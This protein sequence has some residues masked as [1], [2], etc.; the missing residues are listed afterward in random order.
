MAKRTISNVKLGVFVL[1]GLAFLVLLLYMIGKNQNLFGATYKLRARFDNVQGLMTGNNVRYAGI[2]AGTVKEITILADTVIEVTMIIQESMKPVIKKNDIVY[3]GTEGVVGNK[4]INI[5]AAREPGP[6]AE[7]GDLLMTRR[8]VDPDEILQTLSQ[9]NKDVAVIAS[10]LKETVLNINNS[11][12]LWDL[13]EDESLPEGIRVSVAN[14]RASTNRARQ[15]TENFH[16]LVE[17]VRAG[18]G[19]LGAVLTDTMFAF[20]LRE[21]LFSMNS[22]LEKL[23][24]VGHDADSLMGGFHDVLAGIEY[25]IEYGEGP[26]NAF[27]KDSSL[28]EKLNDALKNIEEGTDKF[29]ENMEALQHNFLFRG[30]FRK[31]EK[32]RQKALKD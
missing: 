19:S 20:K 18:E 8:S 12:A 21:A 16:A 4:V 9:T 5:L 14:I 32:A 26:A 23:N 6:Q 24:E 28:V 29:D 25:D 15:M 27:L 1:A 17:D 22:A 2:E 30:Y 13:L 7:E 10:N 11:K 3:I 31:K